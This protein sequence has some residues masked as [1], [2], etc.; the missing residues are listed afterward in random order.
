MSSHLAYVELEEKSR[1]SAAF[2]GKSEVGDTLKT[3]WREDAAVTLFNP[4]R[5]Q[6]ETLDPV[7]ALHI[8]LERPK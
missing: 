1:P 4:I 5:A 7:I 2:L 6:Q 3:G 8:N